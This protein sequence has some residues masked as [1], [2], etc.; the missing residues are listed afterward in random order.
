[1]TEGSLDNAR[2]LIIVPTYNERENIGVLV[3]RLLAIDG[4]C[5]MIV[6]DGSPDGTGDEADRMAAE[7]GGRLS[8]LHRRGQ[9][10]LGRS[11]VD[12]MQ[13]D[14][15]IPPPDP[16]D[17]AG[18]NMLLVGVLL[19]GQPVAR[20]M[21]EAKEDDVRKPVDWLLNGRKGDPPQAITKR[22]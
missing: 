12:G 10:G 5:V 4:L 6:D 15:P 14:P 7:S 8:V 21:G 16:V 13:A 18:S 2:A 3:P 1:M 19:C 9:R 20:V 17:G 22:Y 11:Y